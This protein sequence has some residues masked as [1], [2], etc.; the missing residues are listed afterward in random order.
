MKINLPPTHSI[1]F[2][3]PKLSTPFSPYLFTNKEKDGDR[4]H[5][6]T[7]PMLI[8]ILHFMASR[9]VKALEDD[10]YSEGGQHS[11]SGNDQRLELRISTNFQNPPQTICNNKTS[12]RIFD[13]R[14]SS[15][16]QV[17]RQNFQNLSQKSQL[18]GI[19]EFTLCQQNGKVLWW[20]IFTV[21][22]HYRTKVNSSRR[23][24]KVIWQPQVMWEPKDRW[25][26]PKCK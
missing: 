3:W 4:W 18:C 20:R 10:S 7:S 26:H 6:V 2:W 17:D 22:Y 23:L 1:W 14:A 21:N 19:L 16:A 25:G 5:C 8:V 12:M 9:R 13:R 15:N 11:T 24:S